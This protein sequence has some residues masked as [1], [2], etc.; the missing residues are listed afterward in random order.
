MSSTVRSLWGNKEQNVIQTKKE[1][2]NQV[3]V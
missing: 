3:E 1:Q 2:E